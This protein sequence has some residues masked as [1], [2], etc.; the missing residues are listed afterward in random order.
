MSLIKKFTGGGGVLFKEGEEWHRRRRIL[1]R[2][3]NF[4]VIKNSTKKI[5]QICEK[6]IKIAEEM[7]LKKNKQGEDE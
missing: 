3:F 7:C 1:N 5:K 4:D 2:V 6:E